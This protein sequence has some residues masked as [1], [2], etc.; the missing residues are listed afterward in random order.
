M[1][2]RDH[3]RRL[4]DELPEAL[5]A[6]V[7][8]FAEFIAQRASREHDGSMRETFPTSTPNGVEKPSS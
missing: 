4:I 5:V 6:Q 7:I 2:D 1:Q 3:L 8:N